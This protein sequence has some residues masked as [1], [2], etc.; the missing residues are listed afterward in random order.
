MAGQIVLLILYIFTVCLI[1]RFYLH[2]LQAAGYRGRD[3]LRSLGRRPMLW[4]P[5]VVL[6]I[7]SA[8]LM[9]GYFS[10]GFI[11]AVVY[12]TALLFYYSRFVF[13]AG[14][15]PAA[16]FRVTSRILRLEITCGLLWI[17]LVVILLLLRDRSV[18]AL[19]IFGN[20]WFMA[21]PFLIVLAAAVNRPMEGHIR[22]RYAARA[23]ERIAARR[24]LTVI[25]ISGSFGKTTVREALSRILA[26]RYRVVQTSER[27]GSRMG[28]A[29]TINEELHQEDQ[30][31][32][33]EL[34]AHEVGD[35]A[36]LCRMVQPSVGIVTAMGVRHPDTFHSVYNLIQ[37]HYELLDSV[38]RRGGL[39]FVNGDNLLIRRNMK[40]PDAITYG[41]AKECSYRGVLL[42]QNI[43]GSV[44]AVTGP[45]GQRGEFRT[46]ML[47]RFN[48]VDLIGAIAVA[49]R[50]GIPMEAMADPVASIEPR[51]HQLRVTQTGQTT[52]IDDTD[53]AY[54]EATTAALETLS[55][56][57]CLRILITPGVFAA[58]SPTPEEL[59]QLCIRSAVSADYIVLVGSGQAEQIY[60]SMLEAGFASDHLF[61]VDTMADARVL[62]EQ[63]EP[64]RQRVILLEN[65]AQS[66]P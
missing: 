27:G 63:L 58:G 66:Q 53:N 42:E 3:F 20:L 15:T 10:A 35:T 4:Q 41:F 51:P 56:F 40:Y 13:R 28:I 29:R 37:A 11:A 19:L 24:D 65:A 21:Q 43:H 50:L 34:P 16:S 25:G 8:M 62:T 38:D 48:L 45:E 23:A 60:Q 33:C 47:G 14:L 36:G 1:T 54:P 5:L 32:V 55:M 9:L 61:R 30:F 52:V 12:F 31:L 57:E 46:Q 59:A 64:S 17:G 6:T 22:N 18:R 26:S 39:K 44:F 7:P 49:N 2:W